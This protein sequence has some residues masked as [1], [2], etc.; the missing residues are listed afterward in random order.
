MGAIELLQRYWD[1]GIDAV[2][3]RYVREPLMFEDGPDVMTLDLIGYRQTQTYTC[4]FTAG[5]SVLHTFY[6]RKSATAFLR[7]VAPDPSW[8]ASNAQL[9]RALRQSG[10]GVR[11]HYDLHFER[12]WKVI[13]GGCPVITLVDREENIL[14]WVVLYGVKR[15]PRRSVFVAGNGFFTRKEIPWTEFTRKLWAPEGFG[16]ACWG[17]I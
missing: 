10:I 17:A 3:I 7:R 16:L 6:P 5:L 2:G 12:L 15:R 11:V 1:T 13:D 9:V 14:H 4:G 8:G